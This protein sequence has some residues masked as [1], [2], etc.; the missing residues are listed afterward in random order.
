MFY[1]IAGVLWSGEKVIDRAHLVINELRSLGK[2]IFLLTN[3]S[4]KTRDE[5]AEKCATLGF[6]AYKVSNDFYLLII[7]IY[8]ELKVL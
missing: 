8:M 4:T 2:N 5:Y 7:Y 3:N 1:S 6:Q